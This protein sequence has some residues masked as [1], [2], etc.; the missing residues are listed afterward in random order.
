MKLKDIKSKIR[1]DS[2]SIRKGIYTARK[3]FYYTHGKNSSDLADRIINELNNVTIIDHGQQWTPFRGG[4]S[5]AKS[6]H[7]WVKFTLSGE[8]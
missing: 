8:E 2:L 6:S 5:V 3:T 1:V 7:W 4:S